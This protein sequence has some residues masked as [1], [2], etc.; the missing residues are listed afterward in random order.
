[1][2]NEPG[3][4]TRLC[5]TE[6][7]YVAI[8]VRHESVIRT[9]LPEPDAETA[10]AKLHIRIDPPAGSLANSFAEWVSQLIA[11]YC[12][13]EP[14]DLN[15]VPVAYSPAPPKFTRTA[16]EACRSIPRGQARTY[17]WL[18]EQAGNPSAS[19]AAGRAM[20]TNP[21]PLLV[22]CHRIVGSDGKLTGFGGTRGLPL[23]EHL[24]AMEGFNP[25]TFAEPG[26]SRLSPEQPLQS[27]P[28]LSP[29]R[30]PAMTTAR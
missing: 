10:L 11:R 8:V 20:A 3:L 27:A 5:H 13:G 2:N 14:V 17:R 16:R 28:D 12:A 22:P 19:R 6:L 1:M 26:T 25:I 21:V 4:T 24:L 23:K 30:V 9:T 29:H 18:A 7:G 15:Q